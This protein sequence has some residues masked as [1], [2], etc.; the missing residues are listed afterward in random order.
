MLSAREFRVNCVTATPLRGRVVTISVNWRFLRARRSPAGRTSFC[1][2]PPKSKVMEL[3]DHAEELASDLGVDKQEVSSDLEDLL[4]YSVPIDEAKQSI[5]RKHGS[6]GGGSGGGQPESVDIAAVST[7]HDNVTVTATV[8]TVG[9]RSIRYQGEEAVIREGEL[10]DESDRI[11]YTA[12]QD[13][14]FETGDELKIGNAGVREW[15]GAP[16]L[17][18]GESTSVAMADESITTDANTT[19]GGDRHLSALEPGDRGRNIE[20]Q[21]LEAESTVIDGRDGETEIVEGVLGDESG[22][23]PFTDWD[24]RSDIEAD[25]SLRVE[26]VY[27]R[28]FRGVPSVNLTEFTQVSTLTDPVAAKSGAPRVSIA[29]AIESGGRFDIE[30][31]GTI[32]D[33]RDGSGLIERCPE[34]GRAIQNSQCREHGDVDGTDDL[35]VKAIVDDGTDTVTAILDHDLTTEIYGGGLDAAREAARDA[36][37]KEVVS[38]EIAQSLVGGSYR[39]RG[40][41]SVDDYGANLDVA[42]F[43]PA[44]DDPADRAQTVLDQLEQPAADGGVPPDATRGGESQ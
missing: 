36:M 10:A 28:E 5:R 19:L 11:S 29:D 41:L 6:G 35:R 37:D 8:L 23:L 30:V 1:E 13:F 40:K 38:Q 3:D 34:C 15:E 24:P 7:D 9:T 43:Q 18:L 2:G 39:I 31:V 4:Q 12:W 14:G 21:V 26:D 20:V 22:R 44:D 17:N 32:L 33:I 42:E 27:V 16:E 25:A